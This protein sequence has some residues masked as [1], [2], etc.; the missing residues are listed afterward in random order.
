MT[1]RT[2]TSLALTRSA[3]LTVLG[4]GLLLAASGCNSGSTGDRQSRLI[5]RNLT[6]ELKTLY[7][8]PVDV[9]NDLALMSDEN[10]RMFNQDLG[11]AFYT[12]RPSR[13]TREPVPR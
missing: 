9:K 6:P 8:R 5:R 3:A 1:M 11:R 10:L 2:P 13:L 12:D 4:A 7:Q